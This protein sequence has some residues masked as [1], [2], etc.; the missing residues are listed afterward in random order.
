VAVVAVLV[1]QEEQAQ[2][3][4]K[5]LVAQVRHLQYLAVQ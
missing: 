4:Q 3:P 1:Q 2:L 5:V